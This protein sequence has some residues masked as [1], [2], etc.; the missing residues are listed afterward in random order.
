MWPCN[1]IGLLILLFTF[2]TASTLKT[3]SHHYLSVFNTWSITERSH[4]CCIVW[5]VTDGLVSRNIYRVM[6]DWGC[7]EHKGWFQLLSKIL[8]LF[9]LTNLEWCILLNVCQWFWCLQVRKSYLYKNEISSFHC[10]IE[11]DSY[12]C[13]PC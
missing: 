1:C 10:S 11:F 3:C 4:L 5:E 2:F 13:I 9:Q 6:N 7:F 12:G 8:R